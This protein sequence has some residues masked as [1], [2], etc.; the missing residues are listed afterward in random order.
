[1]VEEI[2]CLP[3]HPRELR[4]EFRGIGNPLDGIEKQRSQTSPLFRKESGVLV[5]GLQRKLMSPAELP[6]RRLV[7]PKVQT[8][9][10]WNRKVPRGEKPLAP[11]K[12]YGKPENSHSPTNGSILPLRGSGS[13]LMQTHRPSPR[14]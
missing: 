2:R 13:R 1:M 14:T 7:E 11:W 12:G 3:N 10:G 8:R 4:E 6:S 9:N 5:K